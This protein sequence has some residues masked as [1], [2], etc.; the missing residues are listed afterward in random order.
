MPV[1]FYMAFAKN[2]DTIMMVD[3]YTFMMK[4][5][6]NAILSYLRGQGQKLI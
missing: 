5:M 4:G 2:S 6:Y 3:P 1:Y